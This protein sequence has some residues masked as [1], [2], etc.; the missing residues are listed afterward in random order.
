M[1]T[2]VWVSGG[3]GKVML[4]LAQEALVA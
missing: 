2:Y 4:G 1:E 3:D